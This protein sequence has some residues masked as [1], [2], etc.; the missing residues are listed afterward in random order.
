MS[1]LYAGGVGD[2]NRVADAQRRAA[3]TINPVTRLRAGYVFDRR[4]CPGLQSH[5]VMA[6]YS[7]LIVTRH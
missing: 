3:Q 4:S 6:A 2:R 5:T 7:T 1:G